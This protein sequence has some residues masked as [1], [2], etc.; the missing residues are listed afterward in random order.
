MSGY[1]PRRADLLQQAGVQVGDT[2]RIDLGPPVVGEQAVHLLLHVVE[3]GVAEA[4]QEA[5]IGQ[6]GQQ[7]SVAREQLVPPATAA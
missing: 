6:A 2:L 3:L 1:V 5:Q 4:G 7:V